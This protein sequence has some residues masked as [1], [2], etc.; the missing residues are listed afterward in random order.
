MYEWW[1]KFYVVFSHIFLVPSIIFTFRRI[2]KLWIEFVILLLI[3]FWSS[4]YHSCYEYKTCFLEHGQHRTIDHFFA[5]MSLPLVFLYI[6][7]VDDIHIKGISYVFLT[8]INF[9]LM[10]IFGVSSKVKFVLALLTFSIGITLFSY[11][12]KLKD[13]K[14][15]QLRILLFLFSMVLMSFGILFFIKE[16]MD[17]KNY[18][19][20][21]AFWHTLVFLGLYFVFKTRHARETDLLRSKHLKDHNITIWSVFR[22]HLSLS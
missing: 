14:F 2:E 17:S 21:H 9:I 13:I 6:F 3:F 5:Q 19:N 1:W 18:L 8:N 10:Q 11:K 16:D 4:A 12:L 20:T 7:R 15:G 22:E